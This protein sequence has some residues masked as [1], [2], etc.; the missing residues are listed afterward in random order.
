MSKSYHISRFLN[1]KEQGNLAQYDNTLSHLLFH[2]GIKTYSD[3]QKFLEPNYDD[4]SYDPY[5]LKDARKSALRIIEA[6]KSGQKIA[7][8]AD[9]DADGI[10]G[11]SLWHSFFSKIGYK[12]FVIYIPH[13]HDE[14]FG[15]NIEAVEQLANEKVD[16]IVTVDCGITD[17]LPAK[18]AKDLGVDLIITDHHEP[19][20]ILPEAYAIIDHKQ[21]DC[22]YPDKNICGSGVAYKLIQAILK[23]DRLSLSEGHEKWF[24]DL[25]G[26]ATLSDMVPL[27]GEN[28]IF[29][30]YGLKVLRKSPRLGLS[31]LLKKLKINQRYINE[32]DI[33]YMITPRIN[34]ASRMGLPMDAFHLLTAENEID[35]EKYADH[36]DKINNERK[37]VVASLVKD[38]KK[39]LHQR[40]GD[41]LPSV[42]VIGNPEW[43]PS[44]LGLVANTCAEEFNRPAFFWGRDGG[45]IIKGSCRS[46]KGFSL[47]EIMKNC[48]TKTFLQFGGHHQSGGFSV[49]NEEI[50]FLE[51]RLIESS[52]N[53]HNK[54]RQTEEDEKDYI[55]LEISLDEI[56]EN[57]VEKIIKLGPFGVGNPRPVFLTKNLFPLTIKKF[58]KK[59]EHIE[60]KFKLKNRELSAISFFSGNS[61]WAE[62]IGQ[63]KKIDLV[64][65]IE[66]SHFRGRPE[67]RLRIL[68]LNVY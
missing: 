59:S 17:I 15:L 8:Y 14:G 66:K 25:V 7:I 41:N 9:Y 54:N 52:E 43:R 45:N 24:L 42:L 38:V 2:R 26:I 30:Y 49:A 33:G 40:Y 32:D 18:K 35:A 67:I 3:A 23:T 10:P 46:P 19:K 58:G 61:K 1:E 68:D 64:Y 22:N 16:L 6:I 31:Q 21:K 56:D 4:Q 11:A 13:R 34:A 65:S 37:G 36:L 39:S 55:D 60:L 29:A 57:F 27:I 51:N 20:D 62:S 47:V 50:H 48:P 44:L 53:L 63:N 28:R 12:N 5:L